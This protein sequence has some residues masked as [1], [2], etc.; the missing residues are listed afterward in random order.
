MEKGCLY[1]R[2]GRPTIY[3]KFRPRRG[4]KPIHLSTGKTN[5]IAAARE[6]E[7]IVARYEGRTPKEVK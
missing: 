2:P 3:V 1:R 4:A 7:K 5:M 6:A